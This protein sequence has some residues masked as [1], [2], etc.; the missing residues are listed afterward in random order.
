M[1]AYDIFFYSCSQFLSEIR[2]FGFLAAQMFIILEQGNPNEERFAILAA[3]ELKHSLST[4]NFL[5]LQHL[6][7]F[8]KT[9]Q[10][11]NYKQIDLNMINDILN[12]M[13]ENLEKHD[14]NELTADELTIVF[15][16]IMYLIKF[17][18]VC[19]DQIQKLALKWIQDPRLK[20]DS[21]KM[22]TNIVGRSTNI[23]PII[24]F[25]SRMQVEDL[26]SCNNY[27][28]KM[29]FVELLSTVM[30]TVNML[31]LDEQLLDF[32]IN[33]V[34]GLSETDNTEDRLGFFVY[35]TNIL[36]MS[37]KFEATKFHHKYLT[38]MSSDK[39][40]KLLAKSYRMKNVNAS[41]IL[42]RLARESNEYAVEQ[43]ATY[44]SSENHNINTNSNKRC[45]SQCTLITVP[46]IVH[47]V[48][49]SVEK[50]LDSL[51]KRLQKE[52]EEN[53]CL[54]AEIIQIYQSKLD[55]SDDNN[56]L[57]KEMIE[58]TEHN[59]CSLRHQNILLSSKVQQS[60]LQEEHSLFK[61]D[62]FKKEN[63]KLK[64]EN[65][66]LSLTVQNFNEVLDQRNKKLAEK[67]KIIENKDIFI[68]TFEQKEQL[69]QNELKKAQGKNSEYRTSLI[70]IEESL[71][72]KEEMLEEKSKA[73][74]ELTKHNTEI[75]MVK[76]LYF[77]LLL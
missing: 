30:S 53:D 67:C 73:I 28:L 6:V 45:N 71:K 18:G 58:N 56:A 15:D 41:Q 46:K 40:Q 11:K 29:S 34:Y 48:S 66:Q 51:I 68:Q 24:E 37:N 31:I 39:I 38:F 52:F 55:L 20:L 14:M 75:Q 42:L 7:D 70:R 50:E 5:H 22:I 32:L 19:V 10:S 65:I 33:D 49:E 3:H 62:A 43:V 74:E 12:I 69:W 47:I 2:D 72:K 76:I 26:S 13:D 36:F 17:E 21:L 64:S 9:S 59:L 4:M 8:L 27:Q 23:Q 57:L 16:V 63:N 54:E 25:L 60:C 35:V 1:I 61:I 77:V 44:L